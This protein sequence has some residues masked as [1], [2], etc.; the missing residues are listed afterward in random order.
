MYGKL[1][2]I[3]DNVMLDYFELLTDVP[4]EELCEYSRQLRE[5]SVNPMVVKKRLSR[6]IVE[7]FHGKKEADRA[8]DFFERTVQQRELPEEIPE[9]CISFKAMRSPSGNKAISGPNAGKMVYVADL[10]TLTG[11]VPSR[12]EARRM[13]QQGAVEV[14]GVKVNGDTIYLQDGMVI[15]VGKRRW[16]QLKNAD[17]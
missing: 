9:Y 1:M 12:T 16:V 4:N 5:G 2:S 13:L 11:I 15:K 8:Q 3:P 14:D 6:E 7:G 17:L 10:L